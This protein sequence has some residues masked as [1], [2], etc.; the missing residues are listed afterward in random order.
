MSHII[1]TIQGD[2]QKWEDQVPATF[3]ERIETLIQTAFQELFD[4]GV[5][6]MEVKQY[7]A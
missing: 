7:V 2:D 4:E 3:K 1:I 5:I 6:N